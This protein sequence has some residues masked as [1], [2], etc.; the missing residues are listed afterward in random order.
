M[1]P[2]PHELT[3]RSGPDDEEDD[4]DDLDVTGL[5]DAPSFAD[6]D[7]RDLDGEREPLITE[8]F[9]SRGPR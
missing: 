5:W 6:C 4:D 1:T 7:P 3:H 2:I 8:T 9:E